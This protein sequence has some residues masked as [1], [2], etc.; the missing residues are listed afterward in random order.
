[1]KKLSII[2]IIQNQHDFI[3]LAIK[4]NDWLNKSK[5]KIKKINNTI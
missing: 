5:P 1:M 2:I 3:D 4:V